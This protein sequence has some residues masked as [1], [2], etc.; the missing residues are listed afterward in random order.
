LLI[1]L[2]V[3]DII[4]LH[5]FKAKYELQKLL[6]KTKN[7]LTTYSNTSFYITSIQKTI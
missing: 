2:Q 3:I 6:R 1:N 4:L 7:I 5:Q